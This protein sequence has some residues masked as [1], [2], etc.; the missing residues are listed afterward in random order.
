MAI[1]T[2]HKKEYNPFIS[3]CPE[4]TG[5]KYHEEMQTHD[6]NGVD[7]MRRMIQK[8]KDIGA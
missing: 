7:A 2:I 5:N 4:C 1:C 8:Q 6:K 3:S